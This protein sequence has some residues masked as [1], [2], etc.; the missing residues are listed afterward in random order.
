MLYCIEEVESSNSAC[1]VRSAADED[2][3]VDDTDAVSEV[4]SSLHDSPR[5]HPADLGPLLASLQSSLATYK[6]HKNNDKFKLQQTIHEME[7]SLAEHVDKI[8]EQDTDLQVNFI[9]M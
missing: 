1:E 8:S 9:Y 5:K 7:K 6:I 4:S 2:D 3:S